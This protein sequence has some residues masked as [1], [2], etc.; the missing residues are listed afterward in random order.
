MFVKGNSLEDVKVYFRDQLSPEFSESE[1][2]LMLKLLVCKRLNINNTE[3]VLSQDLKFS[4]SDLLFFRNV[5]KRLQ[6]D[7]PFQYIIGDVEFCGVIVKVD[8]RALIP[9]PETEEL[10][11]WVISTLGDNSAVIA[12][13]C[14]GSGCIA[15][16]LKNSMSNAR[17]TAIEY[18]NDALSLIRENCE[19]SG[20]DVKVI[21]LDVLDDD[22]YSQ[23]PNNYDC[24]VSN[25]PYIP[26]DQRFQMKDNVL[27]YEPESAL[28]VDNED[29]LVFYKHIAEHALSHLKPNGWLFFEINEFYGNQ[30]VTLLEGLGFVNIEM[31]KDL[32]GKQRMIK[33]QNVISQ[34]E[35]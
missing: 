23:L 20:L 24:W 10:V 33:A 3:Y 27:N 4:E 7:E 28:F 32:Q 35:S 29:P 13:L 6:N 26:H 22:G 16:A 34:H 17:V 11:A 25:P 21:K 14:S 2:S 12:D 31:R 15:F 5:V 18:M 19:Y 1:L 30:M 8:K 9:R